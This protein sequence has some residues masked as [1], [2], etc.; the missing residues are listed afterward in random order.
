MIQTKIAIF[1]FS[2]ARQMAVPFVDL[3]HES[4]H[5]GA[6]GLKSYL[7]VEEIML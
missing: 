1:S 7:M 5:W 4:V 3:Y 6:V 2:A